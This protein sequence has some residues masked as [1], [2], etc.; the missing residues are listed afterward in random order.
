MGDKPNPNIK[1][2]PMEYVTHG[3]GHPKPNPNIKAPPMDYLTHGESRFPKV[4]I[5][6]PTPAVKPSLGVKPE[7]VYKEE[8]IIDL[9]DIIK[10]HVNCGF[11][12]GKHTKQINIWLDEISRILKDLRN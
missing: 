10:R 9:L 1:A 3:M 2:P 4:K 12:Y 6:A 7:W 11:I 8:R 5:D